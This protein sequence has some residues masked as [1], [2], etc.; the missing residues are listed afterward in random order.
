VRVS[1]LQIDYAD[2]T[3]L[4][5]QPLGKAPGLSVKVAGGLFSDLLSMIFL[6]PLTYFL[7]RLIYLKNDIT[8][9]RRGTML[10]TKSK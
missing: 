4:Q 5:A 6:N 10:L 8:S 1:F 3:P 9:T 2:W 7:Y